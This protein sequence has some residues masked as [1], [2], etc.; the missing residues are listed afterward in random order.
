MVL[1]V[2]KIFRCP[3]GREHFEAHR[4][5]LEVMSASNTAGLVQ[6]TE[7]EGNEREMKKGLQN[8]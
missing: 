6:R 4:E 2:V 3:C 7:G 1:H 8:R 5:E